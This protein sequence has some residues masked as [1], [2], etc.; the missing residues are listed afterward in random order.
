MNLLYW[1]TFDVK[2]KGLG[3]TITALDD[4]GTEIAVIREDISNDSEF[5]YASVGT[6]R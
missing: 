5:E 1:I 2:I 4:G 6:I 3:C